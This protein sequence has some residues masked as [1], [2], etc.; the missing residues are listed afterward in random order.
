MYTIEGLHV[1]ALFRGLTGE[2]IDQQFEI[3]KN[4]IKEIQHENTGQY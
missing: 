1:M 4:M 3:L 2:T